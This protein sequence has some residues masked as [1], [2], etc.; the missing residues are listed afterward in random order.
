MELSPHSLTPKIQPPGIRSLVG[1]G[2]IAPPAPFSALPPSANYLRLALQLF[3]GEPAIAE[4]DWNFTANHSS[5][6][7]VAQ[8]VGADLL[9]QLRRIHPGH[10]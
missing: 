2:R 4:F 9:R 8:L 10:G 5:S 3:R 1:D 6:P 7:S